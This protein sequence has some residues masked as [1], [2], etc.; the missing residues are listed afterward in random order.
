MNRRSIS[1]DLSLLLVIAAVVAVGAIVQR[2]ELRLKAI[3]GIRAA[4]QR[5]ADLAAVDDVST[6]P[7]AEVDAA[8]E[9]VEEPEVPTPPPAVRSTGRVPVRP[10]KI[11]LRTVSDRTVRPFGVPAGP[12][13]ADV[14]SY[15]S[16][17]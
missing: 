12:G 16:C 10:P 7:D 9:V 11:H 17:H 2:P 6:T 13:D 15:G 1:P 8:P 5:L 14:H 4:A 3:G